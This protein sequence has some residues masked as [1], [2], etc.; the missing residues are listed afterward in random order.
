MRFNIKSIAIIIFLTALFVSI[1]IGI[2]LYI[3]NNYMEDHLKEQLY[4]INEIKNVSL[5]DNKIFLTL[6]KVDNLKTIYYEIEKI[7][8]KKNYQIVI[9]DNSSKQLKEIADESELA[10]QEAIVRGNF[11]DMKEYI[12]DIALQHGAKI[13]IFVDSK[14]IYFQLDLDQKS[15]YRIIE[16]PE[17][18]PGPSVSNT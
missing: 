3:K 12:N 15:L 14:R 2:Q 6:E 8:E 10:L 9:L 18:L 17:L 11:T 16:R 7:L 13:K 5:E 1:L 4:Q